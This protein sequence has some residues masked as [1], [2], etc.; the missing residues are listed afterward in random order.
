[1]DINEIVKKHISVGE[2]EWKKPISKST[3]N[4]K[5]D[6]NAFMEEIKELR[7]AEIYELE[8]SCSGDCDH[9]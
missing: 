2:V 1:M 4:V 8:C 3:V 9:E 7:S 6:A 5:F